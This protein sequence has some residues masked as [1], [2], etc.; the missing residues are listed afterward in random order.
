MHG[1]QLSYAFGT[2]TRSFV[3]YM[4]SINTTK[5]WAQVNKSRPCGELN[6]DVPTK[7]ATYDIPFTHPENKIGQKS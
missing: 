5:Y 1:L 7:A 2:G 4:M 6:A 3:S